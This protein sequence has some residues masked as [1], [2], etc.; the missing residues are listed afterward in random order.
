MVC[1]FTNIDQV[2]F[3][4]IQDVPAN[5]PY[6]FAKNSEPDKIFCHDYQSGRL[7]VNRQGVILLRRGHTEQ[8]CV[9][10]GDTIVILRESDRP[11]EAG[12]TKARMWALA[13][14]WYNCM[15]ALKAQ[16]V[17]KATAYNHATNSR[18]TGAN[19]TALA[20]NKLFKLVND[21]PRGGDLDSLGDRFQTS[22]GGTTWSYSVRWE[23]LQ[24]DGSTWVA[25]ED[26]RPTAKQPEV[27]V[28][29]G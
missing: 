5:K 29:R 19:E 18:L 1:T 21:H 23:E 2:T 26:P 16:V 12:Y 14:D 28:F 10:R 11:G 17:Y 9:Q 7:F 22:V 24:P 13:D 15:W 27:E 6:V 4:T 20:C 25:C 3:A 8:L